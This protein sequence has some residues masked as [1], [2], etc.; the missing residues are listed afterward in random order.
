MDLRSKNDWP[1]K[2]AGE[3]LLLRLL[4]KAFYF[5]PDQTWIQTIVLDQVFEEIPFSANQEETMR[6]LEILQNWSRA[7]QG[8]ISDQHFTEIK[9][10]YTR[11]FIGLNKCLAA[12]WESVYF[13]ESGLVFREQTIQVRKWYARFGLQAEK[14]YKEPDDHIGLEMLFV[15][16]LASLA[17]QAIEK[18]ND[19]ELEEYLQA[20]RDFLS[21]HL[22]RWGPT[23][24]K[25]VKQHAATDFYRGI[26]HLTHGAFLA[27]AEALQIEMPKEAMK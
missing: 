3:V 10:D 24:T 26:A 14:L 20:Q 16:H 19:R 18:D 1:V 8:G 25:L 17:L 15:A 4:G 12:P 7:N 2:L 21:E 27:V 22:L 11:L 9:L 5:E 13:N 23:W 6:G